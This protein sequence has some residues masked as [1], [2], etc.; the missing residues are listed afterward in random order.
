MYFMNVMMDLSVHINSFTIIFIFRWT[1]QLLLCLSSL[2][3]AFLPSKQSPDSAAG[4]GTA[5]KVL[6]A[7]NKEVTYESGAAAML[8]SFKAVSAA[9]LE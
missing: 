5:N 9:Q 8:Q 3:S 4:S 1:Y 7:Q 6:Q 2:C